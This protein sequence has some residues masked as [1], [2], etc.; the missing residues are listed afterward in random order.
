MSLL[1]KIYI[2]IIV[3]NSN[4]FDFYEDCE[5]GW[6]DDFPLINTEILNTIRNFS[7]S[8]KLIINKTAFT[9]EDVGLE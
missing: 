7:K 3:T 8:N 9:D 2:N 6:V 4:L 5:I 1:I